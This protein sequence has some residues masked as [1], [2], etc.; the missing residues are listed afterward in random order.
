MTVPEFEFLVPGHADEMG[1]L[2]RSTYANGG[3]TYMRTSVRTNR[4]P[5]D[6]VPGRMEVIRR[7]ASATIVAIGPMLAPAID[8]TSDLDV[9]ILY[10]TS[11][12]P[13]DHETLIRESTGTVI[14]IEPFLEGTLAPKLVKALGGRPV[15]IECI[16]VAPARLVGYGRP[17][18]NDESAGVDVPTLRARVL[19]TIGTAAS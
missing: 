4:T 19:H 17:E 1:P 18:E 3:P 2:L 16:G 13:F 6:V 9:T 8:A 11:V 12:N 10:A 14:A 7:G 5:H 15:I